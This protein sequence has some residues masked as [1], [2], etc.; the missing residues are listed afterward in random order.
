MNFRRWKSIVRDKTVPLGTVDMPVARRVV[1]ARDYLDPTAN[2]GQV[3]V[4]KELSIRYMHSFLDQCFVL[5]RLDEGSYLCRLFSAGSVDLFDEDWTNQIVDRD[6][7]Y[8]NWPPLYDRVIDRG[9]PE[10]HRNRLELIDG[11]TLLAETGI[12]PVSTQCGNIKYVVS[13]F[14]IIDE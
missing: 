3:K 1:A 2:G 11:S 8:G 6:G 13:V 7:P 9:Q 14:D 5:E 12:F 4:K 10:Y